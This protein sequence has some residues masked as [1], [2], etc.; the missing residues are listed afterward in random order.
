MYEHKN[1][2]VIKEHETQ[3][4]LEKKSTTIKINVCNMFAEYTDLDSRALL[5][6][7]NQ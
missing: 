7:T 6:N 3:P 4:V 5:T 1:Q 2:D